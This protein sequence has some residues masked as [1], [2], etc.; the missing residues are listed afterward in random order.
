MPDSRTVTR[1][2]L[3]RLLGR[4]SVLAPVVLGTTGGSILWALNGNPSL[5]WFLLLAGILGSVGSYLTR[6]L[7]DN[8]RTAKTVLIEMEREAQAA[9]QAALDDLDR[10]LVQADQDPR[11]ETALRDMR[12]LLRALE[13]IADDSPPEHL[14]ALI[15][16]RSQVRQLF[17]HSVRALE[18]TMRLFDTARQLQSQE[19]R[20]PLV[21]ERERILADLQA[22]IQQLGSTVVALQR[23]GAGDHARTELARLRQELDRS[24]EV[25]GRVESRLDSLLSNT[26]P[27]YGEPSPRP[28]AEP[29]VKGN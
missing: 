26:T 8:G 12:A 3:L 24:L 2:V 1:R 10:R 29:N 11:P 15:E 20:R 25:A 27:D 14:P 17:D 23:I 18:R 13:D 7:L 19:A 21:D 4:P 28:T 9:W 16:V 6:V 5:G 22:G